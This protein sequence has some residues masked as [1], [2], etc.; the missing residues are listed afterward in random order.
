[1]PPQQGGFQQF[2]QGGAVGQG[3]QRFVK[4]GVIGGVI[5]GIAASIPVLNLLN[6]CFCLLYMVGAVIGVSMYL[7]ENA[8]EQLSDSEGAIIGAIAGATGGAIATVLGWMLWW[9]LAS[10]LAGIYSSIYGFLPGPLLHAMTLSAG[11]GILMIPVNI[12]I[13]GGFGALAGFLSLQLFFKER[14]RA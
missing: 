11:R 5:G 13:A 1:M 4:H 2:G 12:A 6:M 10:V 7:N 9:V 3:A 8:Q 14:R